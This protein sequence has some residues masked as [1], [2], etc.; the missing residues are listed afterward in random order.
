MQAKTKAWNVENGWEK[1]LCA[2]SLLTDP[3]TQLHN[4]CLLSDKES[5]HPVL[6]WLSHMG[7]SFPISDS[8][9]TLVLLKHVYQMAPG[10]PH[11]YMSPEGR[12]QSPLFWG[13]KGV[14]A[15]HL[16]CIGSW[17][18]LA[19]NRESNKR[20]MPTI[21]ADLALPLLS[22]SKVLLHF[23]FVWAVFSLATLISRSSGME[24]FKM[25]LLV[26]NNRCHLFNRNNKVLWRNKWIEIKE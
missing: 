2:W 18:K 22:L 17:K 26:I 23:M 19:G 20:L 21:E 9:R 1:Q 24:V 5:S 6:E 3:P 4:T 13:T 25:L 16:F 12:R 7:I 8:M 14:H 15:G 11:C 10:Q